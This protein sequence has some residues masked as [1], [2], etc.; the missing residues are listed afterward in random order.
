MLRFA[1]V[2][3]R[4][5]YDCR[6][7]IFCAWCSIHG[8]D[9]LTTTAPVVENFLTYLFEVKNL[10]VASITGYRSML[11]TYLREVAGTELSGRR[12]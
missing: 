12:D 6:W 5:I 1:W 7:H 10:A 4:A 11:T 9:P 8:T 3:T 2:S